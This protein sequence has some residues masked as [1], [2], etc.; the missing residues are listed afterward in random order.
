L[1]WEMDFSPSSAEL[2]SRPAS[3]VI[4]SEQGGVAAVPPARP[5]PSEGPAQFRPS[6]AGKDAIRPT[7]R[8]GRPLALPGCLSAWRNLRKMS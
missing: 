2:R 8:V 1:P 5:F 6:P 4:H 3:V 7:V